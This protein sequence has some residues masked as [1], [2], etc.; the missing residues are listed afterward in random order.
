MEHVEQ[1]AAA[2]SSSPLLHPLSPAPHTD[3]LEYTKVASF[4]AITHAVAVLAL[5]APCCPR[6]HAA[7]AFVYPVYEY[8]GAV[9][10]AHPGTEFLRAPTLPADVGVALW[11]WIAAFV[12][13]ITLG[14]R[15][16]IQP[17]PRAHFAP[18]LFI[19]LAL[20]PARGVIYYSKR[21]T[22]GSTFAY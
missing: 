17:W 16:A 10:P 2:Q 3:A 20:S 15:E 5:H 19:N 1:L 7:H 13:S 6:Y 4:C 12:T 21:K 8:C 14:R 9:C 22:L 18:L 11:I